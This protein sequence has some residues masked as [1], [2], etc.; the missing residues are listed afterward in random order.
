MANIFG[1]LKDSFL[2]RTFNR[3]IWPLNKIA[4]IFWVEKALTKARKD[5]FDFATHRARERIA[6]GITMEKHDF[7]SYMLK[8]NDEK[9]YA[10]NGAS[11]KW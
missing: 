9:G 5:E 8:Y 11:A 6:Q 3:F 10:R 2:E 7:M 1:S 4:Y